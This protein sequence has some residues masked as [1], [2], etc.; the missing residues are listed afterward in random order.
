M[1]FGEHVRRAIGCQQCGG[2]GEIRGCQGGP[3]GIDRWSKTCSAE[4]VKVTLF[5]GTVIW[6]DPDECEWWCENW[7]LKARITNDDIDVTSLRLPCT[8]DG[9]WGHPHLGCG[10]R[11]RWDAINQEQS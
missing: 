7:W 10:W 2:I 4:H 8:P 6:A 3:Y 5:D 1:E 9:M 11:P